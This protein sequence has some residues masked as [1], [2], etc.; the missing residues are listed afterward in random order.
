M[1]PVCEKTWIRT[2]I[3]RLDQDINDENIYISRIVM[4]SK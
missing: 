3:Q 4:I 1:V 2:K